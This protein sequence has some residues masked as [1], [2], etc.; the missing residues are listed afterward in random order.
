MQIRRTSIMLS[1]QPKSVLSVLIGAMFGEYLR[2]WRL[3]PDGEPVV[4]ATSRLLPVRFGELPAML[5]VAILD[6]ERRGGS[7]MRWW[8]GQGA[9][10][11]LAYTGDAILMERARNQLLLADFARSGRDDEAS[12]IICA[13]TAKLHL[14]QARPKPVDLMPLERWFEPLFAAA[15]V[16]GGLLG[17]AASIAAGL[18]AVQQEVAT[19]HGDIHHGNILD[20]GP[21]GWLAIDPKGLW[22]E[23][24]FDYANI[25]CNP[26]HQTAMLPGR[27]L[28][29]VDLIAKVAHL[30]PKRLLA[31][32]VAWAGLSA[33]F[34]LEDGFPPD[35][36]LEVG[37]LAA[38]ALGS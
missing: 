15:Q 1:S 38:T 18:L 5:K 37:E 6:E 30:E 24:T 2:C 35:P 10:S 28:R 23:R 4:T 19:L 25:I 9:A 17:Q 34:L 22:G 16:Y 36:A 21:R 33:A 7:L 32:V 29:Q 31:W 8:D 26:D 20:F 13:T 27:F 12:R 14:P 3:V 11:V